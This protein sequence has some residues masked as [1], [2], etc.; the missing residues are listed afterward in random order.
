MVTC[1]T[2]TKVSINSNDYALS[3]RQIKISNFNN[4]Y[5]G[6]TNAAVFARFVGG[7]NS[8][9][10]NV[11]EVKFVDGRTALISQN[12]ADSILNN[13]ATEYLKT[14]VDGNTAFISSGYGTFVNILHLASF[15]DFGRPGYNNLEDYLLGQ[16]E[17]DASKVRLATGDVLILNRDDA[18]SLSINWC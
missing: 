2:F 8:E 15:E 10:V 13:S 12:D 1:N 17:N 18:N 7:S 4:I 3:G 6:N 14:D 9:E 11:Y 5:S 16:N